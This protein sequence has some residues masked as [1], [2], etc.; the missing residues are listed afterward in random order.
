MWLENFDGIF[1]INLPA[2]ADRRQEIDRQLQRVGLS[3]KHQRVVLFPAVRPDAPG[4]FPT[5]GTRGCFLSHLGVLHMA[6]AKGMCNILILEDDCDFSKEVAAMSPHLMAGLQQ[7]DWS[8]FYGGALNSFESQPAQLGL[9]T[10]QPNSA[11][12]GAHC[13]ALRGDVIPQLTAYLEAMLKRPPGSPQG[14]P[15]HVDGAYSWFRKD[16]PELTTL[17][18]VPELAFQ[19]SSATDIHTRRWY[20]RWPLVRHATASVRKCKNWLQSRE[21]A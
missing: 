12:M 14:G 11:L 1:V 18:A 19:R 15:M 4:G 20:D 9:Q 13:F 10:V 3:L 8:F 6:Q 7:L 16:H 21:S 5:I 2:R 17:I